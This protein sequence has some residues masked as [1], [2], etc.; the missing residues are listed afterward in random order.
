MQ[1]GNFA[2]AHSERYWHEPRSYRPQRWLAPEDLHYD[3]AYDRDEKKGFHPF[4]Q[5]PRMCPGREV[6]WMQTRLFIAKVLWTF[7]LEMVPGQDVDW[8]RDFRLWAMWQKPEVFVRFVP[9]HRQGGSQETVMYQDTDLL[10]ASCRIQRGCWGAIQAL[11][12]LPSGPGT[13]SIASCPLYLVGIQKEIHHATHA[14][15]SFS[16]SAGIDSTRVH[17]ERHPWYS[18][19]AVCTIRR[20]EY[21]QVFK[22]ISFLK[23]QSP[24]LDNRKDL[25]SA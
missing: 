24:E 1:Y 8:E 20:H 21:D 7:D 25:S 10:E 15:S 13:G 16:L 4:N 23:W 17:R 14:S 3:T 6:S 18:P 11:S 12:S 9:V 5:G 22:R 19:M 2:F